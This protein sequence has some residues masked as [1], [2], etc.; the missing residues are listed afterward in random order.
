MILDW[1]W[2]TTW[3]HMY[4]FSEVG[5]A[6]DRTHK[7]IYIGG[8]Y[9]HLPLKMHFISEEDVLSHSSKFGFQGWLTMSP[10]LSNA[11][12]KF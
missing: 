12:A 1:Q 4:L 6:L 3:Y 7:S 9:S 8:S 5:Y 10:I 2:D 11:I